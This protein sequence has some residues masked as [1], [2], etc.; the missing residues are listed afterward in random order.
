M[1]RHIAILTLIV[2]M[3]T[4]TG[5]DRIQTLFEK[6]AEPVPERKPSAAPVPTLQIL[7]V[8]ATEQKAISDLL[9]VRGLL[10]QS[11]D[12]VVIINTQL[13]RKGESLKMPVDTD[14]Y[15]VEVQ[16]ITEMKVVLKA[17]KDK[18]P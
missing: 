10:Q 8:T 7:G 4:V 18:K 12:Y 9:E 15:N 13:V 6:E 11:E 1:T 17:T 5:C 3:L 16:S 14:V 2:C